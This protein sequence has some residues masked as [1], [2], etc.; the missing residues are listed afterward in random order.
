M[1]GRLEWYY[2]IK[3]KYGDCVGIVEYLS[4]WASAG[5]HPEDVKKLGYVVAVLIIMLLAFKAGEFLKKP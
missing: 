3:D 4:E 5:S 2:W 1:W